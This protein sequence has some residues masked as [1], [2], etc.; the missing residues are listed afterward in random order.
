MISNINFQVKEV[1]QILKELSEIKN[2]TKNALKLL[3]SACITLGVLFVLKGEN[4]PIVWRLTIAVTMA[5]CFGVVFMAYPTKKGKYFFDLSAVIICS[6]LSLP[7][8]LSDIPT[9]Y[10]TLFEMVGGCLV[11]CV[12][13]GLVLRFIHKLLQLIHDSLQR[14]VESRIIL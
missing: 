12:L 4:D 7:F 6:S 9:N 5:I 11:V 3:M 13:M 1:W 14:L 10:N 8:V 2:T